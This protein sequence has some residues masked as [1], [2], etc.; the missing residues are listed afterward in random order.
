MKTAPKYVSAECR[1]R[2]CDE[3]SEGKPPARPVEG[4]VY[5]I[6]TCRC[7]GMAAI[8]EANMRAARKQQ[9]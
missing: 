9:R 8:R 5:L 1:F 2:Y 6:C 7:H 3:C 4:L